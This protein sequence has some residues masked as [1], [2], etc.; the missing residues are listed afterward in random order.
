MP[1]KVD[2]RTRRNTIAGA[3]W[4][5]SAHGGI[6]AVTMRHV[7]A[8]AGMSLGQ[9]QHYFTAKDELLAFA[10]ELLTDRL[11]A[12]VT[13]RDHPHDI[14]EPRPRDTIRDALAELLP[15]DEQRRTEAHYRLMFLARSAVSTEFAAHLGK[16][17]TDLHTFVADQI[18][19]GQR[20]GTVAVHLAPAREART[21]LAVLDGLTAHVLVGHH[22]AQDAEQA[23]D[24]HLDDLFTG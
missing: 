4:Q 22:S 18:R 3:V 19:R 6:E 10:H 16:A 12:R 15:L 14:E 8:A 7:A 9:V 11:T 5:L 2:H 23:L 13:Q 20:R 21:L 24:D 1:K 17:H